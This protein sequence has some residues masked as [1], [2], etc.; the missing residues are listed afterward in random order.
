MDVPREALPLDSGNKV[1]P[2]LTTTSKQCR[3]DSSTTSLNL[4]FIRPLFQTATFLRSQGWWLY[5]GLTV[6]IYKMGKGQN[7]ENHFIENQKKNIESLKFRTSKDKLDF[8]RSELSER[9]KIR[10][11]KIWKGS[12]SQKS[13]LSDFQILMKCQLPMA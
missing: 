11:L 10:T 3:F 13:N 4:T 7:V 8:W 9:Q 1:K 2:A 5:T 6:G 12:E